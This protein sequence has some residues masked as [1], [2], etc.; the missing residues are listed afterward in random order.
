M[1]PEAIA[2]VLQNGGG[3][4]GFG[5]HVDGAEV[6]E[7]AQVVESRHVVKMFVGE[8]HGFECRHGVGVARRFVQSGGAGL[9][10]AHFGDVPFVVGEGR[11]GAV[12]VFGDEAQHLRAEV[13]PAVN[14][15]EAVVVGFEQ[16]R[17]AQTAV[18]HIR[19][20]ADGT[21]AAHLGHTGRGAGAE[22]VKS[23][24][25]NESV[26]AQRYNYF[27]AQGCVIVRENV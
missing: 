6:R 21:R 14:E 7:R 2:H 11:V 20:G 19:R 3:H 18:A 13:G 10:V 1:W 8:E 9:F 15:Q 24:E 25:Q 16:G 17:A 27:A 12:R 5:P 26:G 23:H 4:V 22:K